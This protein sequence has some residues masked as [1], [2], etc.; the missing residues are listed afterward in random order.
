MNPNSFVLTGPTGDGAEPHILGI[1]R[2][3]HIVAIVTLLQTKQARSAMYAGNQ[4]AGQQATQQMNGARHTTVSRK[5]GLRKTNQYQPTHSSSPGTRAFRA[6]RMMIKTI[7]SPSFFRELRRM[8]HQMRM[9]T[10]DNFTV[11]FS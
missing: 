1:D 10:I 9:R 11:I 8:R 5:T 3:E 7:A 6:L 4:T 2:L